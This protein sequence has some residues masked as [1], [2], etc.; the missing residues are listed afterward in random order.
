MYGSEGKYDCFFEKKFG[1]RIVWIL[2]ILLK[3]ERN[4]DA[5]FCCL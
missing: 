3:S 2:G 1:L 4:E 5:V